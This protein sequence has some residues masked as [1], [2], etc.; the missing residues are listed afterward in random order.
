[1]GGQERYR[2]LLP[3]YYRN[4]AGIIL[5]FDVTNKKSFLNIQQWIR[6]IKEFSDGSNVSQILVGNKADLDERREVE[7]EWAADFAAS[8]GMQY[9]ETSVMGEPQNVQQTFVEL[10]KKIIIV[11]TYD[12][13]KVFCRLGKNQQNTV[14]I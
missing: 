11:E 7:Y 1:M 4:A 9:V 2:A 6:E 12:Y 14:C 5:V 13:G 10:V 8:L 3:G